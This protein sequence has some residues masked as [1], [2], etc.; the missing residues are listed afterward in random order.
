M[1][2]R[3]SLT[4]VAMVVGALL[5][6][7]LATLG[8][9]DLNSVT[10]TQSQLV[11]EAKQLAQGVDEVDAAAT[12]GKHHD[13]LAVLRSA[14]NVLKA[15][16]QLQGEAIVGV[17]PDGSFY[18]PQDAT[19]RIG[20]DKSVTL[21]NS[22]SVSDVE[23][24][25]LIDG[26]PVSGHRGRVAWAAVLVPQPVPISNTEKIN[27]VVVLTRN[28][29]AG[30]GAAALWFAIAS[31]ATIVIALVA[32]TR[33]GRRI[34]RPLQETEG[35]TRRIARGDLEARVPVPER[36]G[37]EL[38]SLANS[39]NQMAASLA[40]AKGA[41]RQFLMSVSHDLRTPLTSVRGFA[42]AI[43]DGATDDVEYAAG[44]ITSEARRLERLVT[45]LLEL[46]KLESGAFSLHCGPV[47]LSTVA[48]DATRAFTPAATEQGLSMAI[49]TPPGEVLCD[50][51]PDRLAQVVA[52]VVENA[53]KYATTRVTVRTGQFER[54]RPTVLV[55]DDGPGIPPEDLERVFE[56]LYQSRLPADR[57][58]SSGLGLAIVDELVKRMGGEV[59]AESPI[60][61][62]GGT[63]FVIVL[64]PTPRGAHGPRATLTVPSSPVSPSPVVASSAV[65]SSAVPSSAVP[66][67]SAT[68]SPAAGPTAGTARSSP[69]VPA[70]ASKS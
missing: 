6:A 40:K 22:L 45:D 38:V 2:R 9:T 29:P 36:E 26:L 57:K 50:A 8:L 65:A 34:A 16:L 31:A 19:E 15:P 60:G 12:T 13:S 4:M 25:Q 39:V 27:L 68:A 47:D 56:R 59:R 58:V 28:A 17:S 55:E 23:T 20:T 63:R 69:G 32:A 49:E 64:E 51:D 30:V 43:S 48:T 21:P 46:A 52:N 3:L 33:L 35:V 1:R 7:G 70:P 61:P 10:Q 42:E 5:F 37:P 44:V 54:G 41:Q 18:N 62:A 67:S 11:T 53:L 24:P 66:S 14:L